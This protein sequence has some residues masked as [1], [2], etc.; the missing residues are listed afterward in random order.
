MSEIRYRPIIFTG[1][2]V[3]ALLN[4]TKTQT[5]RI[6]SDSNS[7]GNWKPSQC[8]MTRAFVDHGPSPIGNPGPYLHAPVSGDALVRRGF[9]RDE[10]IVDRIY[11]KWWPPERLWVRES[12]ATRLDRD[13]LKPSELDPARDHPMFWADPN[14][15][16]TGCGGAAGRRR[17]PFHL[18]RWASRITLDLTAVRVERVQEISEADTR[19][20]GVL[21]YAK[22]ALSATAEQDLTALGM[23]ELLFCSING[24]EAWDRNCWVWALSFR[25]VR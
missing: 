7:L 12:W 6:V 2:M 22:A 21:E 17:S 24:R 25:V 10:G 9:S 23:F 20:E 8:D 13:H 14:T 15:C 4:G 1:P 18:P 11:C 19:A 16:M 3:R 5:R